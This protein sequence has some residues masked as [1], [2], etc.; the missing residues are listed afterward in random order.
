MSLRVDL[1]ANSFQDELSKIAYIP[2]EIGGV[3]KGSADYMLAFARKGYGAKESLVPSLRF[4]G[5][6]GGS[7]GVDPETSS[8][9]ATRQVE[10][11]SNKTP[12]S[13][14]A[15]KALA[16]ASKAVSTNSVLN[17]LNKNL[18]NAQQALQYAKQ[19]PQEGAVTVSPSGSTGTVSK[20]AP[21]GSKPSKPKSSS[22][23]ADPWKKTPGMQGIIDFGD[24]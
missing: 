9:Q 14:G 15:D 1:I 16:Q 19:N 22:T 13:K 7:V 10:T 4:R 18:M 12:E 24:R 17:K 23:P 8:A 20:A 3:S 5:E 6:A 2:A 11:A 21:K